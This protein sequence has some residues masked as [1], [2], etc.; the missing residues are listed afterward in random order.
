[1][2]RH[3]ASYFIQVTKCQLNSK[4][5]SLLGQKNKGKKTPKRRSCV[6][7][8]RLY[9]NTHFWFTQP[10]KNCIQ[11]SSMYKNKHMV[12]G[13]AK[14]TR[15]G[16]TI[17]NEAGAASW[18][19]YLI[20]STVNLSGAHSNRCTIIGAPLKSLKYGTRRPSTNLDPPFDESP[21]QS[22]NVSLRPQGLSAPSSSQGHPLFQWCGWNGSS[23]HEHVSQAW[24]SRGS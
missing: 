15:I 24:L 5:S 7:I 19:M 1:M 18:N 9:P 13:V 2:L 16:P 22:K 4:V 17:N 14:M 8:H 11:L 21:H 12:V 6:N 10:L 23:G 20:S 3:H